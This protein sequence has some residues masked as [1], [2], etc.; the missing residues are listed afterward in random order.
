VIA[1]QTKMRRRRFLALFA[2]AIIVAVVIGCAF[3]LWLSYSKGGINLYHYTYSDN[4]IRGFRDYQEPMMHSVE[5]IG[6]QAP[7]FLVV[8]WW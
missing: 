8:E 7:F 1:D 4:N 5:K 6:W 2:V 3:Q